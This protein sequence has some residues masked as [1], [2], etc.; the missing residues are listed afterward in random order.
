[1]RFK[2]FVANGG[3]AMRVHWPFLSDGWW[4]QC[5]LEG[6]AGA[7]REF[8]VPNAPL[9]H[10]E[11]E[12]SARQPSRGTTQRMTTTRDDR[13]RRPTESYD[14]YPAGSSAS[15]TLCQPGPRPTSCRHP[16]T[17]TSKTASVAGDDVARLNR[18]G[19]Y[20]RQAGWRAVARILRL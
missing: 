11:L 9:A 13:L 4:P 19:F 15:L 6:L 8:I 1:M 16:P 18:I 20:P 7:R 12:R 3:T 2:V 10:D 5:R 17:A 14:L